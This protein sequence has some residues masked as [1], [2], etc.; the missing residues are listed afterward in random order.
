MLMM[1]KAFVSLAPRVLPVSL[2]LM[3][4]DAVGSQANYSADGG[5]QMGGHHVAG[6]KRGLPV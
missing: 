2:R 4:Q 3:D 5:Q 6:G 1:F